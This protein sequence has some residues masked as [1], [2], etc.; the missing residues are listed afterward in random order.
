MAIITTGQTF[1]ATDAVTSTKLQNIASAATFDDPVDETSLEKI[2]SGTDLGKLRIKAGGVTTSKIANN[3]ITSDQ[4]Q[5]DS[6]TTNKID[7]GSVTANKLATDALE[8][9]YP[10]GSIYMNADSASNPS[11]LLG[12]GSW[13]LFSQGTFLAGYKSSD[14]NFDQV[15]YGQNTNG[16][17]GA[18]H[19]KLTSSQSGLP[20]HSHTL[21]GG[22]FNGNSGAEPGNSRSSNLGQTGTT[23]GDDAADYHE[24]MPPYTVVYMWRRTN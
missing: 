22:G 13:S 9:A 14:N 18:V 17:V 8:L 21:L 6:V 24:N 12:F 5:D 1:N 10:L 2:T 7:D 16:R 4:I 11:T 15:G 20:S 23:G 3:T 19:V